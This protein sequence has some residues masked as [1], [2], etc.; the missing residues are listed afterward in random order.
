[1]LHCGNPHQVYSPF[2]TI[3]SWY[4]LQ[5]ALDS[6]VE[7]QGAVAGC[8]FSTSSLFSLFWT[9]L[10]GFMG[11]VN[12]PFLGTSQGSGRVHLATLWRNRQ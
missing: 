4:K 12:Y 6:G 7:N 1:M 11:K 3:A 5:Q 9:A 10:H 8:G 2:G